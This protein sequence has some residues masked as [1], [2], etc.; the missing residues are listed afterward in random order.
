MISVKKQKKILL[1]V[2]TQFNNFMGYSFLLSFVCFARVFLGQTC[3]GIALF[4]QGPTLKSLIYYEKAY[5]WFY[6]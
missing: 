1:V 3:N 5:E 4:C 2:H 6:F